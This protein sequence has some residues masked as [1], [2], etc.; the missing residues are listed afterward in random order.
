VAIAGFV[1]ALGWSLAALVLVDCTEG[2]QIIVEADPSAEGA[3]EL[4]SAGLQLQLESGLSFTTVAVSVRSPGGAT[5]TQN[6]DVSAEDSTISAFLGEL[7]VANGYE[8]TLTTTASNGAVCTG[9]S[10]FNVRL[11]EAVTVVVR[12]QCGGGEADPDVGAARIRGEIIPADGECPAVIDRVTVAPARAGIGVPIA[13]TVVP[14]AGA[15]PAVV[16]S[17][18]DG[19]I[20]GNGNRATFRCTSAGDVVIGIE[21]TRAGCVHETEALVRCFDDGTPYVPPSGGNG[22]GGAGGAAGGGNTGGNNSGGSNS[23]GSNS[24]GTAGTMGGGAGNACQT[25]TA[26]NCAAQLTSC[27]SEPS[28]MDCQA[29]R[30]CSN[31]GAANGCA[32]SSSLACYCGTR[33]TA[34]C[35]TSGGNGACADVITESSGCDDGRPEAEIPACVTE[36]FLDIEYGLGDAYQ[37][38]ACQRRNCPTQCALTR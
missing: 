25:C 10:F 6:I 3:P 23:G 4:G 17:A 24:G 8:V 36:R 32:A 26:N 11:D 5:Q 12:L 29:N 14:V 7:P 15:A 16:Y 13:V 19:V 30:T 28:S 18:D 33:T 2:A 27:Q 38:V 20:T 35:L 22:G 21:A 9:T 37:L 34:A 31:V 1:R